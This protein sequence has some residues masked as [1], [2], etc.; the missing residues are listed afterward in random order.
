MAQKK[1]RGGGRGRRV[2][3][4]IFFP[5]IVWGIAFLVWFYWHDLRRLVESS[6]QDRPKAARQSERREPEER[7]ER[8]RAQE[9][10][11]EEDRKKLQDILK[12][13]S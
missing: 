12:Q 3:F 5:L 6:P 9:K 7:P 2:L 8:N 11:Q 13:R 4:Y 1:K 10:I